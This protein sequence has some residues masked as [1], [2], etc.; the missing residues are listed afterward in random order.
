VRG[1]EERRCGR[2]GVGKRTSADH[3][4]DDVPRFHGRPNVWRIGQRIVLGLTEME[5]SGAARFADGKVMVSVLPHIGG[6]GMK[7]NGTP[8]PKGPPSPKKP[9]T[10]LW[11]GGFSGP[12]ESPT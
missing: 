2:P 10:C 8:V 3:H 7:M 1:I 5:V 11:M 6:R 9:L 12:D 4:V